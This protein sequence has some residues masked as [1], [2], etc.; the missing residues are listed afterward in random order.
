MLALDPSEKL[1]ICLFEQSLEGILLFPVQRAVSLVQK[2]QKQNI[3]F[4]QSTPAL[5]AQAPQGF[6]MDDT[7]STRLSNNWRI[8]P[9][10]LE[11]LSP[12]GQTSV[13]FMMVWQ[14][15]NR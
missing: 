11:G 3:E 4:Q 12:F 7:H 2:A 6:V 14:R 10:A 15:N 5:P 1:L 9:I 8:W 13:Q